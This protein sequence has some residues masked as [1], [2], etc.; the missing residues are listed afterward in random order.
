MD[1]SEFISHQEE[2]RMLFS[3]KRYDEAEVVLQKCIDAFRVRS[4]EF[5]ELLLSE[6]PNKEIQSLLATLYWWNYL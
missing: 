2:V 5:M 6:F 1:E 3:S 4:R